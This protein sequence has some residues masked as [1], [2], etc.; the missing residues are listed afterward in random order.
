MRITSAGSRTFHFERSLILEGKLELLQLVDD[1]VFGHALRTAEA[2]FALVVI[3]IWPGRWRPLPNSSSGR[4]PFL[5]LRR[6]SRGQT[7]AIQVG[8]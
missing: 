2:G 5:G 6:Y 8:G 4:V 3:L 1:F 7:R